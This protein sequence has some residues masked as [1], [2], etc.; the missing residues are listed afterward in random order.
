MNTNDILKEET[1]KWLAKLES[2]TITPTTDQK[3]VLDQITNIK[4]YISDCKHF[5]EKGD[6]VRA[7][8]A[9]IYAWGIAETLER[10]GLIGK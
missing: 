3:N 5:Q 10:L 1:A 9:V 8:E 6:W 4:A 7:F 2:K